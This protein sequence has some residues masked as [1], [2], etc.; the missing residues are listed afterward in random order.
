[1]KISL[2]TVTYNSEAT[3]RATVESVVQ[4]DYCNIEHIIIDGLSQDQTLT[5]LSDYPSI[6]KVISEP[7]TGI[8]EAMNKG[9]QIATGDIIGILNSDDFYV[10]NKVIATIA[11]YFKENT[12]TQAV[13]ANL[14][15]VDRDNTDIIKRIWVAGEFDRQQFL[16]GWTLPHP[17]FFVRKEVYERYGAYNTTLKIA[18]DYELILRFLYKFNVNV[19][20]LPITIVKMRVG[21]AS[22]GSFKK[23]VLGYQENKLAWSAN[24][25]KPFFYTIYLKPLRKLGQFRLGTYL[26]NH[27][28]FR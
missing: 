13:Y 14:V 28:K 18:A 23:R 15:Y 10:D 27:L 4:Q 21:G 7:D 17:T 11:D 16:N 25:L 3:I 1:M 19:A 24:H 2:I 12:L 26:I 9:L 20:Y 6:K 5:I 8:Y 22:N